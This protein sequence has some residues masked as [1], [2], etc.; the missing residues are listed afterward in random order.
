MTS[1]TRT[2]TPADL[3]KRRRLPANYALKRSAHAVSL[4]TGRLTAAGRM[5]PGFL[6]VGAQRCG[7][8]SLYR[9][10][11]QHPLVLKPVLR[12]GVHYFDVAYH[13]G[14][15]W[16][17]AHFPLRTTAARLRRRY[18]H[19]PLAF[20]SSPYYLFHPL[21]TPRIAWDLPGVKLIV[22]VRDPV[23]RAYSAH[24][25]ELARGFEREPSFERAVQMEEERLAGEAER[26]CAAPH[27]ISH[28][29]RHHAYLARG[30][31]AEQLS[32]LELLVGRDR[33]LVLDSHRFFADPEATFDRVLAFLGLP[34]LG[35]PP[36]FDRHNAR[37]RPYPMR[38]G[39][40]RCLSEHFEPWDE[41]L[42]P[43][44]GEVPSWRR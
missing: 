6:I 28:A 19:R 29:H 44:L 15:A 40:R 41:L 24:A 27:S 25:H 31:Y 1:P 36:V 18:G 4:T 39:L 22:L 20:E 23:E 26:L 35:P 17:Q 33:V 30:R 12:K 42:I 2:P 10:L 43:Y 9:A 21:A 11:A 14:P 38:P 37:P 13:R 34:H 7:T 5:L 8:T 16:Y 3:R 32:R